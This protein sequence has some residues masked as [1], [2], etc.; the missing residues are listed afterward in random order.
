MLPRRQNA[1]LANTSLFMVVSLARMPRRATLARLVID[2]YRF[3]QDMNEASYSATGRRKL[4]GTAS[5]GQSATSRL[6]LERPPLSYTDG[7]H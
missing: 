6:D 5:A 4:W 3:S 2:R 7:M 1:K